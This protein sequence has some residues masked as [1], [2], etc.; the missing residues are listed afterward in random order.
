MPGEEATDE[1]PKMSLTN[2]FKFETFNYIHD[3]CANS[4]DTRFISN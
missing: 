3:I 1:R 2:R 4:L